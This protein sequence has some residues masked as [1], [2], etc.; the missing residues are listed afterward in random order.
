MR[1]CVFVCFDQFHIAP[2]K[3]CV[4]VR[5]EKRRE[6]EKSEMEKM[7]ISAIAKICAEYDLLANKIAM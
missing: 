7:L 1:H 2:A 5:G 6:R 4:R 3:N